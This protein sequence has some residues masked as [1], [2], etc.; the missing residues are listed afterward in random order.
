MLKRGREVG[1]R[2]EER[3]GEKDER[4]EGEGRLD[5]FFLLQ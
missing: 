2:G 5:T 3:R 4:E 1:R